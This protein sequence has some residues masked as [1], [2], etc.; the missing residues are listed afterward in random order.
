MPKQN[1]EQLTGFGRRLADLRKQAGYTQVEL[2]NEL[3]VSQRMISYYEGH[4]DFPPSNLLPAMAKLL[5]VS[6]DELLGIKP[7]KKSR[8]PDSRLLRRMQQI[9]KLDAATKRQ[10]IQ[11][12]DTFIENA[13]LK[14]QA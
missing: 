6:A 5:G 8:Q 1:I 12:I 13:K 7:L 3:G 14:K 9:D 11:V 4:S 2:A 10:V